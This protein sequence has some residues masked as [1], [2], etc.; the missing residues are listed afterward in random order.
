MSQSIFHFKKFSVSNSRS[1]QKVGTDGV[2]LGA[3]ALFPTITDGRHLRVLDIGTGTGVVALILAQRAEAE[4]ITADITA[5][6]IDRDAASEAAENFAESQW[7]PSLD[8][9]NISLQDFADDIQSY[10]GH[11]ASGDAGAQRFDLIVSNPPYYDS[12]LPS[13]DLQRNT[14]RHTDSLSYREVITF[15]GDFLSPEGCLNLILPKQEETGMIRFAA[16][17]GLYPVHILNIRT[18]PS[19]PVRRI[20]ASLGRTRG[21]VT[22]SEVVIQDCGGYTEDY[23][24]L[25]GPY[26]IKD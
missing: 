3:A 23:K 4:G 12:S 22:R 14:A 19:K 6:D 9:V 24:K 21:T 7:A 26:Y 5:I 18:T 8:A 2:L 15:S 25:T 11:P 16:S 17:F 13:A 20:V 10:D 1:A